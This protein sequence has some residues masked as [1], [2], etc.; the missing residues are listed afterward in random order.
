MICYTIYINTC[1]LKPITNY[2]LH[3]SEIHSNDIIHNKKLTVYVISVAG[4]DSYAISQVSGVKLV[5]YW[6]VYRKIGARLS[7]IGS[8]WIVATC[9]LQR[10]L[11]RFGAFGTSVKKKKMQ[12]CFTSNFKIPLDKTLK[13]MLGKKCNISHGFVQL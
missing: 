4:T 12:F 5:L 6:I 9:L 10:I 11:F 7:P 13:L 2:M 8:Q 1:Y 3:S